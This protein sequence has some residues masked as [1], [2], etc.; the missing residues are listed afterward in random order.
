VQ[1]EFPLCLMK[2]NAT[3]P[4]RI[5]EVGIHT[6]LTS[7]LDEDG[8]QLHAPVYLHAAMEFSVPK[9]RDPGSV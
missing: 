1:A 9:G 6:L 3:V 5:V 8:S 4:T 7:A 2:R